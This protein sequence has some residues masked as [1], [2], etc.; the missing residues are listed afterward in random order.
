MADA[1]DAVKVQFS[2]NNAIV[3]LDRACARLLRNFAGSW[4]CFVGL[5]F[6][7]A[8][9]CKDIWHSNCF[10]LHFFARGQK[11]PQI[12]LINSLRRREFPVHHHHAKPLNHFAVLECFSHV[13][14][15]LLC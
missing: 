5:R 3:K 11:C 6:Q 7:F 9:Q 14:V 13:V 12:I 4:F 8:Q 15:D 1:A 2:N 10:A